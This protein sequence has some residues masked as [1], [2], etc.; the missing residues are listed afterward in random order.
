M[1]SSLFGSL[2]DRTAS[3]NWWDGGGLHTCQFKHTYTRTHTHSHALVSTHTH[4]L[5]DVL[6]DREVSPFF[7]FNNELYQLKVD[8]GMLNTVKSYNGMLVPVRTSVDLRRRN[9]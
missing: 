8:V 6:E 9:E 7:R 2:L 5:S 3:S 1:A 4:A